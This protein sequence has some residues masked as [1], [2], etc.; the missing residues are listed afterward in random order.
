MILL[1][2]LFPPEKRGQCEG[3]RCVFYI[4]I[5]MCI[6]TPVGSAIIKATGIEIINDLGQTGYS[7]GPALF[8]IAAAWTLLSL[9]PITVYKK[10]GEKNV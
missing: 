6:G 7:A 1:K 4:L 8:F 10:L 9:V 5:P 3:L 2:N